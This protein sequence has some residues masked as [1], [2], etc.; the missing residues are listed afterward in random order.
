MVAL[1]VL[2]QY[3]WWSDYVLAQLSWCSWCSASKLILINSSIIVDQRLFEKLCRWRF[4]FRHQPGY[5][6]K[7][8]SCNEGESE[9]MEEWMSG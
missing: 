1:M 8:P 9:K 4:L 3:S 6:F 2:A 7:A 5:R